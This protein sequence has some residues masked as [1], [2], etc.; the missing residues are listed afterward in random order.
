MNIFSEQG[1]IDWI[2][3]GGSGINPS[4]DIVKKIKGALIRTLLRTSSILQEMVLF[5]IERDQYINILPKAIK[6]NEATLTTLGF[7]NNH[8]GRKGMVQLADALGSCKTL[9]T[10]YISDDRLGL[11]GSKNL[12]D[13]LQKTNLKTLKLYR[14]EIGEHEANVLV[15]AVSKNSTLTSLELHDNQLKKNVALKLIQ[16][17]NS[18]TGLKKFESGP[19]ISNNSDLEES[20]SDGSNSNSLE[21]FTCNSNTSASGFDRNNLN[22]ENSGFTTENNSK[23][24][25]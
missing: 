22:S 9:S 8:L 14:V 10:L 12:A 17:L 11:Y 1:I 6:N 24:I 15:D 5:E 16:I 2:R 7:A 13:I 19:K 20:N 21:Y 3:R 23:M 18:N 4:D 25:I